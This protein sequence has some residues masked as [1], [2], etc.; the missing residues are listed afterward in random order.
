MLLIPQRASSHAFLFCALQ[1]CERIAGRLLKRTSSTVDLV[2]INKRKKEKKERKDSILNQRKVRVQGDKASDGQTTFCPAHVRKQSDGHGQSAR[3]NNVSKRVSNEIISQLRKFLEMRATFWTS[4]DNPK[5]F[6]ISTAFILY[7]PC[8]GG[9]WWL[10]TEFL[11]KNSRTLH[12][13]IRTLDFDVFSQYFRTSS[14]SPNIDSPFLSTYSKRTS[15][16]TRE[17]M[18]FQPNLSFEMHQIPNMTLFDTRALWKNTQSSKAVR[19]KIIHS[20]WRFCRIISRV[21]LP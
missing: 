1:S 8:V 12:G 4:F 17:S 3:L 5:G 19:D 11:C 10:M 9:S 13:I 14:W 15:N 21:F 2:I 18:I 16:A 7:T 6:L 20:S